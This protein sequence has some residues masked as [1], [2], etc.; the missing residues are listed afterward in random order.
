MKRIA[1]TLAL[2][3]ALSATPALCQRSVKIAWQPSP[4]AA[5]NPSLTYNVYRASTCAGQFSKL[6]AAGISATTY[7]DTA[8]A[9]GAAYCYQVTAILNG[10]ES[11]PS[12]QAIAVIPPPSNRQDTCEHRGPLIGWLRCIATRPKKPAPKPPTP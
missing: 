10:V 12:N 3:S 9:V 1:I 8:V 5:S 6:N 4:D 2:A 11:V 7:V